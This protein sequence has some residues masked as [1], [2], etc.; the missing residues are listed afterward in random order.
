MST[1]LAVQNTTAVS[2]FFIQKA[3]DAGGTISPMKLLKLAYISHGWCLALYEDPLLP[4]QIQAWQYGPVIPSIYHDVKHYGN[5]PITNLRSID[6][7][8]NHYPVVKDDKV[9]GLLNKIWEVYGSY[10]GIDLSN[11]THEKGSPW[12]VVWNEQGGK[13]QKNTPI[14]NE[15]IKEFYKKKRGAK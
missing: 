14:P 10:S 2:N 5:T 8:P 3:F 11:L 7:Y 12:D 4:E 13:H 15:L 6:F 1:K 9:I